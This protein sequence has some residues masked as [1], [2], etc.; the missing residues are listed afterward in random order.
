M[1]EVVWVLCFKITKVYNLDYKFAIWILSQVATSLGCEW[2]LS[3]FKQVHTKR[4][5][6]LEHQQL[7]MLCMF[8]ITTGLKIGI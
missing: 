4:R 5:N 6:R 1:V 7:M 2:S 8:I 3:V